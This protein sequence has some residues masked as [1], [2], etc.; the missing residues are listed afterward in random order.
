MYFGVIEQILSSLNTRFDSE[1]Y[2]VLS[3]MEDFATQKCDISQIESF[4]FHNGECDF[5]IERLVLHRQMFFD[6]IKSQKIILDNLTKISIFMQNN[7]DVKDFCS[8]YA[9]FIKLLLTAP[10]SVC[11]FIFVVKVTEDLC[12]CE[13]NTKKTNDLAILYVHRDVA[14]ELDMD[15]LVDEFI[16]RATVRKNTFALKNEI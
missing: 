2:K 1:S 11:V 3:L 16:R 15:D 7:K 8:E 12:A 4:L 13:Y 6:H 14:N 9:K 10:Q 5:D